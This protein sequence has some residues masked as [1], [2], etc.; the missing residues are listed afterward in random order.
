MLGIREFL[1]GKT[2]FITGATGF[3]GQPLVEKIL[4]CAPD[5]KKIY[6]LIRP[7]RQ[8]GGRVLEAQERLEKE[9][10]GSTIFD[11]LQ[12]IYRERLNQFLTEK[13]VAVAGDI[14]QEG[15]GLEPETSEQLLAEVDIV[16]NSAAVVSFDADLQSALELN[17]FGAKRVTEFA[18]ACRNAILLHVSTAYVCGAAEGEVPE[19]M[20]HAAPAELMEENANPFPERVITDLKAEIRQLQ[21]VIEK[22]DTEAQAPELRR[23]L[24]EAFLKRKRRA[25]GRRRIRRKEEIRTLKRKWLTSRLSEE[26]M[27]LARR[28]GWNDT[29]TYTKALGEQMVLANRGHVPTAIIR[30]S[31]I[32]SSLS[33]PSPGW[34]DGLRMADPLIVAIGKGR[35]RSLPLD[36][37]VNLDLVPA[38]MVVSAMLAVLP[39]IRDSREILILQV[40]TGAVNPVS[41]RE[42]ND[43]IFEYFSKNPLLNKQ[44][45]AIRLKPLRFPKPRTFRWQH[46]L[47]SV[48]LKT[49][50][51]TLEILPAFNSAQKA[52]RKVSAA[53]AAYDKLYHYGELYEPYLNLTCSFR[54]DHTLALFNSLSEEEKREFDFDVSRLNWRHYIQNVH[55]PGV[56]K[57]ILKI[58][59]SGAFEPGEEA[60]AKESA[61]LTV[62]ELLGQ[63][64]RER[65]ATTA[66][67]IKRNGKWVRYSYANLKER[68]DDVA[69]YLLALGLKKGDRVVLY[70]ENQPEWGVSYLG[71]VTAGL[72]VVPIDS[73]TWH[74]EAWSVTQF[75]EARALLASKRCFGKLTEDGLQ[76][77]ETAEAPLLLLQVEEFCRPFNLPEYPR[78]TQ[79][80]L[81]GSLEEQ[82]FPTLQSDDA[83]S[84]IFTTGT[85]VDPKG[86]VHSHRNFLV[87]LRSVNRYLS[88]GEGDQMLSVLPLYH[89]LEFSCGFLGALFGGATVTYLHSLKPKVI[90]EMMRET[91]TTC[92]LGV[93][94][95]YA[96]IREDI[97]RRILRTSKSSLKNNLMETSKQLSRS[98][99]Q[100][101]GQNIGH[102]LFGRVHA[103]F[104]GK[105]RV[106]VSGGSALGSKLYQ[107]FK[108]MGI[109]IYEGYGLTETAPVLT[110]N[111]FN[112]SR[113]GSAG[114]PL[115][116]VELRLYNSDQ[117]GIGEILVRTPSLMKEYYRNPEATNAV[118]K[119]G[120]FRTGDLGWVDADGYVYITGRTKDVIVTGAGKNVYPTDLE[121]IYRD[122]PLINEMCVVGIKSGL[123]EDV[124]AV[125]FPE[126]ERTR[127]LK[128]ASLKKA[129]QA[130]IQ[131]LSK[132][133][134]SYHRLQAIHISSDPLT[135]RED[136]TL[137][138]DVIRQETL[139]SLEGVRLAAAIPTRRAA[140]AAGLRNVLLE[141]LSRLS[142]VEVTEIADDTH[143]YT[144]LGLDSLMAVELLLFLE[145]EFGLLCADEHAA[146]FQTVGD[147]VDE[148]R[149]CDLREEAEIARTNGERI[150]SAL[151]LAERPR[152][153][154]AL[155]GASFSMMKGL[156]KAYFDLKLKNPEV[157]PQQG[158]YILAAN[159]ASHL[160]TA[161]MISALSVSLGVERAQRLHVIGARDYF[162]NSP[163]KSW[164]FSTCLNVVPIERDEI[165]LTGLR[166]LT[167]ILAGGEPILIFPEGT[168]SRDGALQEFRP[169]IGLVAWEQ[170]TTIVPAFISGTYEAMPAGR[171][172]PRKHRVEV[173]FGSPIEM[174]GYTELSGEITR[175]ELYRK[176]AGDVREAVRRLH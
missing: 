3:L 57:F 12:S 137:A 47:R 144:D 124:H 76:R 133:L 128:P 101:F 17:V 5:V 26:G 153:D 10:Y 22:V 117:D 62:I 75:T 65:P 166:Q 131:K 162:F 158:A 6:V 99:E 85:R 98:W 31:I 33:E 115:P 48:P 77:N 90:L 155:M 142:G 105:V 71:A 159:H 54:V 25:R 147:V 116:G 27:A 148:L 64:A 175:D 135:R 86:A 174:R 154:R 164:L 50:A 121:A 113:E 140:R 20:Y 11:R 157:L 79:P 52:K 100:T 55:I 38:D 8:F 156:F 138:R 73:Q 112:R 43:L 9:L 84:I 16:M 59:G 106:F 104:G 111:P 150:R 126:K 32:E 132:E 96:L 152:S 134:P 91:G 40:A 36:P 171:S 119:D 130:E 61:P 83:I 72:I 172:L 35:L 49:A 67:Q 80:E 58:E 44:G 60:L 42:L 151:P 18:A 110:V 15:L 122:L 165:S 45:E 51:R 29:Y 114:K 14:S 68:A 176:I 24:A 169:G 160:D 39:R 78:S 63:G 1:K 70:A 167:S 81:Q 168:R 4:Y 30:P 173:R 37:E 82:Q 23:Q 93:P 141:E 123:T 34:L 139:D 92:M 95:L 88:V 127:G 21:A 87:N 163:F 89:A 66:L 149:K 136:G 19:T 74:R 170:Q 46:Q 107:D 161:A 129:V 108:S 97:E 146:A 53:N 13:L 109:P 28:R 102:R 7:K 94:T 125:I 56:K 145:R 2:I 103:E 118:L 120:W 143:L 69:R 41:L